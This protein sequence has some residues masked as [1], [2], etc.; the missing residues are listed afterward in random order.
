MADSQYRTLVV[1]DYEPWRQFLCSTIQQHPQFQISGQ[2]GDGLEAVL[3]AQELQPDLILLDVGLPTLNGIEAA[4]RIRE[5][6]PRTKILFISGNRSKE[7]VDEALLAGGSGYVIKSDAGSELWLAIEALLQDKRFVSAS[8][9]GVDRQ[10]AAR[11]QAIDLPHRDN[12]VAPKPEGIGTPAHHHEAGFYSEDRWLLDDVTQFVGA[13]LKAGNAAAVIATESHR[14]S[15]VQRLHAEG[16]DIEAAL[17]EGRCI[18]LDVADCLPTFIVG[19]L[20]DPG[21]FME[22]LGNLILT[23]AKAT[24]TKIRPR[25]ALYG[26]CSPLL[27]TQGNPQAAIQTE[28]IAN[29]LVTAYDVDILCGYCIGSIPDALDNNTFQQIC[30]QH[31]AVHTK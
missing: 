22:V 25:V 3:Q 4:R 13:A 20:P 27:W 31:T 17:N 30:I 28:T 6:S 9:T 14:I 12:T 29:Q 11:E 18:A 26:E 8:L 21:R 10:Y 15:L 23:A 19:G 16:I 24:T 7:I 1:D 2:A 5:V